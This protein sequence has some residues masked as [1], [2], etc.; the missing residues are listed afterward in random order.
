MEH[1]VGLPPAPIP[2]CAS[3]IPMELDNETRQNPTPADTRDPPY[4]SM[5]FDS[6]FTVVWKR[7]SVLVSL[8]LVQ[9]L[10]QFILERY[11]TLISRHV[12]ISLFL[13]MLVGAGGNAGNQATVRAITGLAT[14]SIQPRHFFRLLRK[15]FIAGLLCALLLSGMGF[16][17]VHYFYGHQNMYWSVLA[18]SLSLFCIVLTSVILGAALPFILLLMRMN[19]EHAAPMI[20]VIMDIS[21][22]FLTC[23]ICNTM[24]P[25]HEGVEGDLKAKP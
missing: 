17:R 15:E 5:S 24:I 4:L 10:S 9:S 25:P 14:G 8:L 22:V 11:E 13:T 20:Q 18:I 7:T 12:I 16:A 19:V 6:I 3:I 1:T 23:I 21:G 2:P